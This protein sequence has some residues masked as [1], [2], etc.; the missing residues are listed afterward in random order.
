MSINESINE[1]EMKDKIEKQAAILK[2]AFKKIDK[3]HDDM[4]S[5]TELLQFLE[6]EGGKEVKMDTFKR[7]FKSIDIDSDGNLS[8]YFLYYS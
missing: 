7:L 2:E 5:E 8:M 3:N 6:R 4:I 1:E